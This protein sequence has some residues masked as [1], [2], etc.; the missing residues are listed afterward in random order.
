[1]TLSTPDCARALRL[2]RRNWRRVGLFGPSCLFRRCEKGIV[3]CLGLLPTAGPLAVEG[4]DD[5]PASTHV[6]TIETSLVILD[7]RVHDREGL[8]VRGLTRDDFVI[9][10]DGHPRSIEAVDDLC[11]RGAGIS[12]SG[13]R[14]GDPAAVQ[15]QTEEPAPTG[16]RQAFV[17]VLFLDF[18]QLAPTTRREAV[19]TARRWAAEVM[20][21]EDRALVYASG[22]HLERLV[23]PA[24]TRSEVLAAL[25]GILEDEDFFDDFVSLRLIRQRACFRC[26]R[27][28]KMDN[29]HLV[30]D[31]SGRCFGE[32]ELS[33]IYERQHSEQ[34]LA[35]LEV[36]L[37]ELEDIAGPKQMLYLNASGTLFPAR[38]YP[39]TSEERVGDVIRATERAGAAAVAARTA[40][41]APSWGWSDLA[42]NL[43]DFSGGGKMEQL[44]R[45][46]ARGYSCIYRLSIR[47][48]GRRG[49]VQQVRV[50]IPRLRQ[51][52]LLRVL[53]PTK[54]QRWRQRV[55]RALLS[56]R[57]TRAMPV[58]VS[59]FPV[60]LQGRNWQVAVELAFDLGALE[61]T[62][63]ASG[64]H[65]EWGA[66]VYLTRKDGRKSWALEKFTRVRLP[67]KLGGN[68]RVM[69]RRILR[70]AAGEYE[71]RAWIGDVT[72]SVFGGAVAE[73]HLPSPTERAVIGPLLRR[74]AE[75]LLLVALPDEGQRI[76]D[77]EET[78]P[79]HLPSPMTDTAPRPET[80]LTASTWI[81]TGG[82]EVDPRGIRRY[83]SRNDR[84]VYRLDGPPPQRLADTSCYLVSDTFV[85]SPEGN[86]SDDLHYHVEWPAAGL[87]GRAPVFSAPDT[88]R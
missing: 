34:A 45:D 88:T 4:V 57:A 86:P 24:G 59:L 75:D 26:L 55:E 81:C 68:T 27:Q 12:V 50:E 37:A 19:A 30:R 73:L 21:P 62:R 17:F 53:T 13:E 42:A 83:L 29:Q 11:S 71:S 41:F 87:A 7:V 84:P 16:E 33:A 54:A 82:A 10:V 58:G 5:P 40:I 28:C 70:L 18:Q 31:C 36:L 6:E 64:R 32:C 47:P 46:V 20:G 2:Q 43:T 23:A 15:H 60:A 63:D 49:R 80:P 9:F 77:K 35:R 66:G 56:P 39:L 14:R 38:L 51:T 69:H 1:M 8:P 76:E 85:A 79:Q 52:V 65:T 22:R 3:I 74:G 78:V 25:D 44:E 67:A 72:A 48:G 61:T